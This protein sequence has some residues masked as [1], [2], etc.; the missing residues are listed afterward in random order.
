MKSS[1]MERTAAAD[2]LMMWWTFWASFAKLTQLKSIDVSG[3]NG[4]FI[5][6]PGVGL[7]LNWLMLSDI[8]WE[9]ASNIMEMEKDAFH[10]SLTEGPQLN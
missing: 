5:G 2:D 9:L 10:V 1:E 3:Q 7:G 4:R 8:K 6:S